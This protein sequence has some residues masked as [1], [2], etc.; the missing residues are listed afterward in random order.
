MPRILINNL[1]R[2]LN[3]IETGSRWFDQSFRDKFDHLGVDRKLVESR[4]HHQDDTNVVLIEL[5]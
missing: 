1:I 4:A 3:E 2:Q 5:N